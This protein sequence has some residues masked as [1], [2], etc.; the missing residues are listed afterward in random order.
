MFRIEMP[1]KLLPRLLDLKPASNSD[2]TFGRNVLR[3]EFHDY[4]ARY[5]IA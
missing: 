5:G 2:N 4:A 3:S 1:T